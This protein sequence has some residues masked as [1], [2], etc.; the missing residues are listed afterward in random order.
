MFEQFQKGFRRILLRQLKQKLKTPTIEVSF[1]KKIVIV[2]TVFL[3]VMVIAVGSLAVSGQVT[4]EE[5]SIQDANTAINQAFNSVLEAEKAGGNVTQ[6]LTRLNTA[7]EQLADAESIYQSNST[8]G[9]ASKANSAKQI[10]DEINT[11]AITLKDA[12]IT[13]T[14]N[15]FWFIV[16]FSVGGAIIFGLIVF[17]AWQR[18]RRSYIKKMLSMKPEVAE[19]NAT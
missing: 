9:V 13:L 12:S 1:V 3:L 5:Q 8:S 18:F 6:L 10:A 2:T 11:E 16:T 7:G 17:L 14:R 4:S 15:S 19:S